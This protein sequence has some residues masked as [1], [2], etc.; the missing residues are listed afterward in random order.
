MSKTSIKTS[1]KNQVES[2][3]T[4]EF[5][6]KVEASG[7]LPWNRPWNKKWPT[8]YATKKHYNIANAFILNC[9]CE[10]ITFKQAILENKWQFKKDSKGTGE[11]V[12][13]KY[14]HTYEEEKEDK[15]GNKEIKKHEYFRMKYSTVFPITQFL[16]S[17]GNE[18][19]VVLT[20]EPLNYN[21]E[22]VVENYLKRNNIQCIR[23]E[24]YNKAFYNTLEDYIALPN[25]DS[26]QKTE[27]FYGT[28]FHEMTHSTGHHSRLNRKMYAAKGSQDYSYEELVAEIGAWL[29]CGYCNITTESSEKNSIAY[30]QSWLEVLKNNPEW[31]YNAAAQAEKAVAYILEGIEE[32]EGTEKVPF[33]S[34]QDTEAND[35]V[36]NEVITEEETQEIESTEELSENIQEVVKTKK[37]EKVKRPYS[38]MRE[39]GLKR[40]ALDCKRQSSLRPCLGYYSSQKFD[41]VGLP[42]G[43]TYKVMTDSYKMAFL[44]DSLMDEYQDDNFPKVTNFIPQNVY[45]Y[46][47]KEKLNFE[48]VK[49]LRKVKK[50]DNMSFCNIVFESENGEKLKVWFMTEYIYTMMRIF[51]WDKGQGYIEAFTAG[52][53]KPVYFINHK[54]EE[55]FLIL[56]IRKN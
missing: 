47:L 35:P 56:P 23:N 21:C 52:D 53:L 38:K 22:K 27:E 46:R 30:V 16:D 6:Q 33:E 9:G 25:R 40:L 20:T 54:T 18:I 12:Y 49:Q 14:I 50:Y 13:Q 15:E 51:D 28:L 10:Y 42:K 17:E 45:K 44:N 55:M 26:F 48:A 32:T 7:T 11:H 29:L 31:L 43:K 19:K 41:I 2:Y 4:N 36:E 8:S 5:I 37:K 39:N 34:S 24:S 1:K 3:L